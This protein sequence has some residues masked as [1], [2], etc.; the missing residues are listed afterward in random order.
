MKSIK[1]KEKHIFN[2][3]CNLSGDCLLNNTLEY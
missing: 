3:D 1:R 2:Q